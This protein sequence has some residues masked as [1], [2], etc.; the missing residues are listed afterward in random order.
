MSFEYLQANKY[1]A[2]LFLARIKAALPERNEQVLAFVELNDV[3]V[4]EDWNL[5]RNTVKT[6]EKGSSKPNPVVVTCPTVT[7]AAVHLQLA[8]E[9]AAE[10]ENGVQSGMVHD[11]VSPSVMI[12]A[13]IELQE[14]Q[15]C[16]WHDIA[17][18]GAHSTD[19]QRAKMIER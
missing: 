14:Q 1:E 9:E 18:L 12:M 10:L 16:L 4:P 11:L 2:T 15:Y 5:W 19:L 3:M 6:W 7:Q 17:T 13:G 8:N